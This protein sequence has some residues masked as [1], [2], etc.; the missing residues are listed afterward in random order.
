ED[1]KYVTAEGTPTYHIGGDGTV[2][3]YTF[4]GFRR[5]HSE[6]HVCHGPEGLGSS[7]APGLIDSLKN[8]SYEQFQEVVVNGRKSSPNSVM[9]AF[10]ENLNVMCFLDDIYVYLKARADGA[11]RPGRPAKRED[12]P[13][14]ATQNEKACFGQS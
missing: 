10:G 2:D 4:S 13:D 1:G 8:L 12:K 9:P 7:F 11:L 14:A 6:C 3:W 5:Y